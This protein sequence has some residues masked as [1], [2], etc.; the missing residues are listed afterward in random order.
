MT[1]RPRT[2]LLDENIP[3]KVLSTLR[4]AGYSATRVFDAGL[5]SQ[6]D[7]AIFTYARL[8]QMTII[9]YDT[10]YLSRTNFPPPHAGLIVLRFFL[11]GTP[12]TEIASAVL[13]AVAELAPMDISNRVYTIT[14]NGVL[15]EP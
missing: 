4:V 6:S 10:D 11:R 3:M 2:F 8:R 12:L 15:E 7:H 5:G 9:T 14:P 1:T 13:N